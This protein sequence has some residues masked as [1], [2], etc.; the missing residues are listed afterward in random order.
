MKVE[1][2][3]PS[4]FERRNFELFE[5]NVGENFMHDI[6]SLFFLEAATAGP[7]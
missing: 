2:V 6:I 3:A 7:R 5:R 1:M 4:R